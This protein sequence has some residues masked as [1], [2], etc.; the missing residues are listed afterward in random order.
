M[1]LSSSSLVRQSPRLRAPNRAPL[2]RRR[3]RR[4]G[5]EEPLGVRVQLELGGGPATQPQGKWGSLQGSLGDGQGHEQIREE[6]GVKEGQEVG[7][8]RPT[9]GE[10]GQE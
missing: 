3:G 4:V 2:A 6:Q 5:A 7:K 10:V 1:G 8:E 9:S